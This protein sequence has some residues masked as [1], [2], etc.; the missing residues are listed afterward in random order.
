MSVEAIERTKPAAAPAAAPL[1]V[2]ENLSRSYEVS[3]GPFRKAGLVHALA[4]VSFKL[5]A[6]K[7]SRSSAN[8]A[9]ANRPW[10]A[11]SP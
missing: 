10:A 8:P 3:R 5:E 7:T 11:S 9:P 2:A 4:G 1:V 6:G